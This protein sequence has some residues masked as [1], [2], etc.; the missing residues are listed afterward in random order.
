[1]RRWPGWRSGCSRMG[2]R[3]DLLE[4]ALQR[5]DEIELL[6]REAAIGLRL[7][8]EMAV[9][10]GAHVDRPVE[11]EMGAGAARREIEELLPEARKLVRVDLAGA[12][13]ID[14]DRHRLRA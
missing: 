14:I 7:A 13:S 6:P 5:I 8:A 4:S 10:R 1:M 3:E 9:G 12:G 2:S 11:A